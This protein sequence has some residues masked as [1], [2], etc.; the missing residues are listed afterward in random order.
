M[1]LRHIKSRLLFFKLFLIQDSFSLFDWFP[2][3]KQKARI[4]DFYTVLSTQWHQTFPWDK[5]SIYDPEGKGML[6]KLRAWN[7]GDSEQ[8]LENRFKRSSSPSRAVADLIHGLAREE[9]VIH[10]DLKPSLLQNKADTWYPCAKPVCATAHLWACAISAIRWQFICK[11]PSSQ[12]R[13][14]LIWVCTGI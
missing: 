3:Q 14:Y 13:L 1:S 10:V 12:M 2:I 5:T 4:L 9:P 7:Q 11:C 6:A 8:K